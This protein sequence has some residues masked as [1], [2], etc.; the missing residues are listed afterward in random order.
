M[1][2]DQPDQGF[3]VPATSRAPVTSI[4]RLQPP[5]LQL[6]CVDMISISLRIPVL[7]RSV[8]SVLH[9][10]SGRTSL[11]DA[12]TFPLASLCLQCPARGTFVVQAKCLNTQSPYPCVHTYIHTNTQAC[13]LKP[14][15][16]PNHLRTSSVS[17]CVKRVA[18]RH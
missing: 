3:F 5:T 18:G 11:L 8:F 15:L 7:S 17:L 6:P 12:Q 13:P 14:R 16:I 1:D 4:L 10:C 9:A 2:S